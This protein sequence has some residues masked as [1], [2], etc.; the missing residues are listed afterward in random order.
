VTLLL[1][2]LS[3]PGEDGVRRSNG[4]DLCQGLPA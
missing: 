4:G 1:G 3:V 2:K